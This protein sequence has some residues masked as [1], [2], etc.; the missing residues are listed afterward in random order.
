M[1]CENVVVPTVDEFEV[2]VAMLKALD[3]AP[4]RGERDFNLPAVRPLGCAGLWGYAGHVASCH[5]CRRQAHTTPGGSDLLEARDGLPAADV[6]DN[7][8]AALLPI[9]FHGCPLSGLQAGR[10]A[11][12]A[13]RKT[14]T[15]HLHQALLKRHP[16]GYLDQVARVSG[17][18]SN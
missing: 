17:A 1:K 2:W 9:G 7:E 5:V 18:A 16:V 12:L 11:L 4:L 8:L 10:R 3:K 14:L 6:D 13:F 15:L